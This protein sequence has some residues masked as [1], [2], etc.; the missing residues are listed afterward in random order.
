MSLGQPEWVEKIPV[1]KMHSAPVCSLDISQSKVSGNLQAFVNFLVQGG[2]GDP[3]EGLNPDDEWV[4]DIEDIQQFIV[5]FWS[6]LGMAECI[7]SIL[8]WWSIK[9]MPWCC[10][11][12]VVFVMAYF[13]SKWHASM[14]SGE[15]SLSQSSL[16]MMLI[17]YVAV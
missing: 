11:Q 2:I 15:F 10:H 3:M 9:S 13:T 12:F 1:I 5:L 6:D 7:M 17:A 14:H 4:R 16:E 8:N